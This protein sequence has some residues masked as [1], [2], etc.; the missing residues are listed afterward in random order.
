MRGLVQIVLGLIIGVIGALWAGPAR[1]LLADATAA[2]P[3]GFG[4]ALPVGLMIAGGF[5]L[6]TGLITMV[7]S[8]AADLMAK[9][10]ETKEETRKLDLF[11]ELL[12]GAAVRMVG[13]DGRIAD[14]EMAMV[15]GVLEKFGQTPV[16]EKTI[17]SIA[18]ASAKNPEKYVSMMAEKQGQ[19]REEQKTHILR[20]CLLVA[21]ADVVMDPAELDYLNRV[22]EALQV[23]PERL[24][25]IRDELAAVTQRLVG[26]AAFAA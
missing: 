21:M 3:G 8:G 2:I 26:A 17:R 22:A 12:T 4:E 11:H 9:G 7:L 16:P 5:Y 19:L 14:S 24:V 23:A 1:S 13:A 15:S 18:E 25:S 20:A 10:R 6:V